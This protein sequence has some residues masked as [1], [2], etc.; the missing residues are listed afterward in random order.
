MGGTRLL[1]HT[2]HLQMYTSVLRCLAH[3]PALYS[4]WIQSAPSPARCCSYRPA[5]QRQQTR[6]IY[7]RE[8]LPPS[9]PQGTLALPRVRVSAIRHATEPSAWWRFRLTW[10][11]NMSGRRLVVRNVSHTQ[12]PLL[13]NILFTTRPLPMPYQ[14]PRSEPECTALY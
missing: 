5:S 7:R 2:P 14:A 9:S 6:R 11:A 8:V 4:G 13:R 10:E 12:R 1:F 3:I